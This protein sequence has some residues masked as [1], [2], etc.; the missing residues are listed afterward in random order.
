MA[1]DTGFGNPFIPSRKEEDPSA[2]RTAEQVKRLI[3]ESRKN[4]AL[5]NNPSQEPTKEEVA[6]VI[7]RDTY[8]RK[9]AQERLARSF[10]QTENGPISKTDEASLTE[11]ASQIETIYYIP[12]T[13]KDLYI[14]NRNGLLRCIDG[15]NV[16]NLLNTNELVVSKVYKFSNNNNLSKTYEEIDRYSRVNAGKIP[17]SLSKMLYGMRE[18]RNNPN[19]STAFSWVE[20]RIDYTVSVNRVPEEGIF[21]RELDLVVGLTPDVIHPEDTSFNL[22]SNLK[23]AASSTNCSGIVINIVDNERKYEPK[24]I[25]TAGNIQTVTPVQDSSLEDGVS[26]YRTHVEEGIPRVETIET[27]TVEEAVSRN[28][29]FDTVES[30]STYGNPGKISEMEM[31][32][33]RNEELHNKAHLEKAKI[34]FEQEKREISNSILREKAEF[35]LQMARQKQAMDMEIAKQ[36]QEA[37]LKAL[38]DKREFDRYK[39]DMERKA[40]E[41]KRR[42]DEE[43]SRL[44][45]MQ[46]EFEMEFKR[47][48]MQMSDYYEHRSYD[49]KDTSESM[50]YV[51]MVITSIATAAAAYLALNK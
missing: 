6:A 7:K 51:P 50:K 31:Q 4:G 15:N 21:I 26:I 48:S 37:E 34:D 17:E 41:D 25:Y 14:R 10:A 46:S 20:I 35:E 22:V 39:Q 23:K 47:K 5:S 8:I 12:K 28:I 2:W 24:Y 40:M 3:E 9:R 42:H 30:A 33:L 27:M 18:Y 49:R 38:E 13:M 43:L 36:K 29:L 1:L 45:Q 11:K 16:N 44:K 32:K 19:R